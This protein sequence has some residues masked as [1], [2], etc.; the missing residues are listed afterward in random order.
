MDWKPR[1]CTCFVASERQCIPECR[2]IEAELYLLNLRE[3]ILA[4]VQSHH[5]S[6]DS[7]GASGYSLCSKK[8][9]YFWE[10][11]TQIL[12]LRLP[13]TAVSV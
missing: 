11:D 10:F 3:T 13:S 5:F 7:Y 1:S 6:F 2:A 8:G 12:A 9:C 4:V